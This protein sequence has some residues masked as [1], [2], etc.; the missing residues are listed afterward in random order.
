M[1]KKKENLKKLI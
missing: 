1:T